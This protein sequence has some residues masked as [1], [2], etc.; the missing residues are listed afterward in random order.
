MHFD[1]LNGSLC[2]SDVF[3]FTIKVFP[4]FMSFYYHYYTP[5]LRSIRCMDKGFLKLKWATGDILC[6]RKLTGVE[7]LM[8]CSAPTAK[9]KKCDRGRV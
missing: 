8:D 6:E 7:Q 4:I 9:I 3:I 1:V 2:F 5:I